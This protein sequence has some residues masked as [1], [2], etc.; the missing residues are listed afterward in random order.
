MRHAVA[1]IMLTTLAVA[2]SGCARAATLQELQAANEPVVTD[3]PPV[4]IVADGRPAATIVMRDR[5]TKELLFAAGTLREY[6][7]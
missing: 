7:Q 1:A 6:V 3:A 4:T 2:G 5:P